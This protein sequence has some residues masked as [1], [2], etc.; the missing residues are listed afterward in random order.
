MVLRNTGLLHPPQS[1]QFWCW[2]LAVHPTQLFVVD[3]RISRNHKTAA[4]WSRVLSRAGCGGEMFVKSLKHNMRDQLEFQ[5]VDSSTVT[6]LVSPRQYI[7]I[8]YFITSLYYLISLI[9]CILLF[10]LIT[11]ESNYYITTFVN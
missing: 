8:L 1:N 3:T 11:T 5:E 6:P 9:I 7:I 2:I 4:K 10:N